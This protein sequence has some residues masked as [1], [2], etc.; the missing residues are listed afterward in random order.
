MEIIYRADDGEEF[1]TEEA[2]RHY[3][4]Q[5]RIRRM[6]LQSRFFDELGNLLPIN[7]L[8]DC[9]E[10]GWY[11]EIASMEEAQFIAEYSERELC[12]TIF[13]GKPQVG[14][15]YY[16]ENEEWRPI[17]DLYQRY[18]KVNDIFERED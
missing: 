12:L 11:M 8:S 4:E 14:R 18:V 2:C 9:I 6:N 3:E 17:E 15:F 7:N 16:T 1:P 5:N 13:E 10:S